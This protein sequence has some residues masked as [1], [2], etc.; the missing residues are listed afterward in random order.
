MISE[1]Q[2]ERAGLY[3]MGLLAAEETSAFE[4]ELG[5][6]AELRAEVASLNNATLA[7]ARSAPDLAM[8]PLSREILMA[9]VDKAS[10]PSPGFHV[11]PNSDEGWMDS[12]IPGIRVKPLSTSPDIGHEMLLVE[13]APGARYPAHVHEDSEQLFLISGTLLT[14]GRILGPG[15]F[16][17]ASPGTSHMELFSHTGCRAILVRRAAA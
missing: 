1:T 6:N 2:Q 4:A 10:T 7:L 14:E 16:F 5:G 3:V 8:P 11:V 13:F 17:H 12:P 15:D 9:S